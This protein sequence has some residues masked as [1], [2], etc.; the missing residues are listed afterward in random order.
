MTINVII[1]SAYEKFNQVVR[2]LYNNYPD[3]CWEYIEEMR[4]IFYD[5]VSFNEAVVKFLIEVIPDIFPDCHF[6]VDLSKMPEILEEDNESGISK[7][8]EIDAEVVTIESI[9]EVADIKEIID[10][11][12]EKTGFDVILTK[13]FIQSNFKVNG[14]M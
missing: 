3:V 13:C 9:G 6:S 8:I 12:E 1:S 4:E 7:A 14:I 11:L 5:H 2:F 10:W